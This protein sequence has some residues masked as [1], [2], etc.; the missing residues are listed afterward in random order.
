M[1]TTDHWII[2]RVA[3]TLR[4]QTVIATDD[5]VVAIVAHRAIQTARPRSEE[6]M[7]LIYGPR[8]QFVVGA[9]R[10][11]TQLTKDEHAQLDRELTLEHRR[12]RLIAVKWS[13]Q[14]GLEGLQIRDALEDLKHAAMNGHASER[15][16]TMIECAMLACLL[17]DHTTEHSSITVS[18]VRR[19][20]APVNN[21][22]KGRGL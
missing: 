20:V 10:F 6:A 3:D 17:Q 5:P 21:I 4:E 1:N 12:L 11:L 19:M 8:W 2:D 18:E 14:F 22:R 9:L 15:S 7:S 13:E 16:I